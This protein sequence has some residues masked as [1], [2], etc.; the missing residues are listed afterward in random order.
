MSIHCCARMSEAVTQ[1]CPDHPDRFDCPDAILDSSPQFN[2]YGFI[3]HDGG[4]GTIGLAF[5]PWC[6]ARLSE[7]MRER[8]FDQL[9]RRGFDDPLTQDIPGEFRTA[10]WWRGR[11][12]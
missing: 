10:A 1:A 5:C 12:G 9:G 4:T 3:V 11:R 6:G 8:W 7:S 2:E